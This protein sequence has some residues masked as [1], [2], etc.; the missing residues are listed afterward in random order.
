MAIFIPR[1]K[2]NIPDIIIVTIIIKICWKV[3]SFSMSWIAAA[4]PERAFPIEY[5][6]MKDNAIII[7][8]IAPVNMRKPD[9]S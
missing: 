8:L 7:V 5:I 9:F 3:I 4:V 6:V 1:N 2:A